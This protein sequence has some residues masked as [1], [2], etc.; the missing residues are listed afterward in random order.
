MVGVMPPSTATTAPV[1]NDARSE[2]RN[3]T[4]PDISRGSA[5]RPS[6]RS[7]V[8]LRSA[9]SDDSLRAAEGAKDRN[10]D[11]QLDISQRMVHVWH[12]FAPVL[13]E[14]RAGI[15]RAAKFIDGCFE[16]GAR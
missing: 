5:M 3:A 9:S 8:I 11:V 16:T 4:S 15:A 6:S 1:M 13:R 2:T 12:L 7:A 14:G 10:V